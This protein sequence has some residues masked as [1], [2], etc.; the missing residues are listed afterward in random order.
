MMIWRSLDR[1]L[2]GALLVKFADA[3]DRQSASASQQKRSAGEDNEGGNQRPMP[4]SG[5]NE[6]NINKDRRQYYG[7]GGNR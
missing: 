1:K 2:L 7:T 6:H 5:R 3:L 4:T